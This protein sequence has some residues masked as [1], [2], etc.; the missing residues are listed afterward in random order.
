M[1]MVREQLMCLRV[2]SCCCLCFPLVDGSV[3]MWSTIRFLECFH[4]FCVRFELELWVMVYG[5]ADSFIIFFVLI[6]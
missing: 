3:F 2:F 1:E 5:V 6:L 4:L